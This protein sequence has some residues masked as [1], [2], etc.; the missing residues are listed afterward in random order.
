MQLIKPEGM[1][2]NV[3]IKCVK[4]VRFYIN[5]E[6]DVHFG[7]SLVLCGSTITNITIEMM[8]GFV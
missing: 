7:I 3:A 4:S 1:Q 5:G 8:V 2:C 6:C